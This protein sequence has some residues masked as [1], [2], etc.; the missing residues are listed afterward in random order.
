MTALLRLAEVS[1]QRGSIGSG[2]TLHVPALSVYPGEFVAVVG[3]SGCGKSTL[4]DL[5][6]LVSQPSGCA[7]FALRLGEQ[8]HDIAALWQAGAEAQLAALRRQYLG[9]VLQ[10]GGLLPF[11]NVLDNLCLPS[12]LNGLGHA[13]ARALEL[14]ERLGVQ[15]CLTRFPDQLSGGQRQRVAIARA[16]MHQPRLL[17]ADEP[18]AAVD[19][20][21]AQQI[22]HD[23]QRLAREQEVAVVIVSHDLRLLQPLA[24]CC[25]GFTLSQTAEG[26]TQAVC[27]EVKYG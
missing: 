12:R 1:K 14:A 9:Y 3:E 24:D 13:R 22:M 6:A 2:F 23:L 26:G 25:Y 27:H 4:L 21:R 19:Q 17:L 16:L 8:P 10:T 5:L 20:G 7:E 18:T 11:L 15:E